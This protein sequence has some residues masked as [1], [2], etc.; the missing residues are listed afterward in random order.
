MDKIRAIILTICGICIIFK[1]LKSFVKKDLDSTERKVCV[2]AAIISFG[3]A[4]YYWPEPKTT[5]T[6]EYDYTYQPSFTGGYRK[7]KCCVGGCLC[8]KYEKKSTFN[9]DCKNCGHHK[10]DHYEFK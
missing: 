4:Y 1:V 6:Y 5:T 8:S 2:I 7:Y 10:G 3:I 9:D